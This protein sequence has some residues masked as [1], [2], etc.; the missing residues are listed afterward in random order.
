MKKNIALTMGD[1]AGIGPELAVKA[2]INKELAQI[3]NII[4]YGSKNILTKA[5]EMFANN[6]ELNIIN[7]SNFKFEDLKIGEISAECGKTALETVLIA[8]QDVIDKKCDAIVTNPINKAAVNRAGIVFTGH[9]ELIAELCH[10]KNFVMMQSS[11][12]LR[13]AFVTTHIPLKD[14]SKA[15]TVDKIISTTKLLN[16]SIKHEGIRNPKIAICAI[17]PHAGEN[18]FMG[19]E[20][21]KTVKIAIAQL[22]KLKI[23]VQGPFPSDTLFI[24]EVLSEFDGIVSMY[25]EQ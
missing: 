4:L 24:K 14:V 2:A 13:I 20:D 23:N 18:G 15:I 3:A 6:A 19:N 16:N 25:H 9:T 22:A 10:K 17:N 7:T 8:T 12:N 21:E 5:N 11:N 1:P